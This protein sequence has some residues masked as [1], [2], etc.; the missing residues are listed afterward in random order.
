M[1]YEWMGLQTAVDMACALLHTLWQGLVLAIGLMVV[2]KCLP[3]ARSAL[4]YRLS[5]LALLTVVVCWVGTFSI[6]QYESPTSQ[7]QAAAIEPIHEPVTISAPAEQPT[8]R[9]ERQVTANVPATKAARNDLAVTATQN[10]PTVPAGELPAVSVEQPDSP[11]AASHAGVLGWVAAAWI[12]GVAVMLGRMF[13]LLC[14]TA[15]LRASAIDIDEP[16][17]VELFEQLC[18]EMGIKRV[19]RFAATNLLTQPGVIGVFRPVLLVPVSILSEI[20]V[21]DLRAILAHEL[22]HIRRYD[23]LV[24]FCQMLIEAVLFFNPGVWWIS[25]RIRIEREACCDAAGVKAAG[26][27]VKYAQILFEQ[28]RRGTAAPANMAVAGFSDGDENASTERVSRIIHPQKSPRMK[29]GAVKLILWLLIAAAVLAVL[30]KATSATVAVT[31]KILTPA[32]R[33]EKIAEIAE[34]HSSE[35]KDYKDTDRVTLSGTVTTHDGKSLPRDAGIFIKAFDRGSNTVHFN[36]QKDGSF[37]HS[38]R[39]RENVFVG[40]EV[41][42]Y[43][44]GVSPIYHP[45][46]NEII[47]NIEIVLTDGFDGKVQV[48]NEQGLPIANAV[49]N[50]HYFVQ[51][52]DGSSGYGHCPKV[53]SD[54]NGIAIFEHCHE[55]PVKMDVAVA[56]Y[57][58]IEDKE[59]TLRPDKTISVTLTKGL[60]ASG[61]VAAKETGKPIANAKFILAHKE[62]PGHSWHYGI[63]GSDYEAI[64]DAAGQF[65]LDTLA[66][67]FKYNYVIEANGYNR[68]VLTKVRPGDK[69]LRVEMLGELSIKGKVIGDLSKLSESYCSSLKKMVPALHYYMDFHGEGYDGLYKNGNVPVE[70]KDSVGTFEL[71]NILGDKVTLSVAGEEKMTVKIT[72]Q[73]VDDLVIDLDATKNFHDRATRPVVFTFQS[74]EG[75]PPVEGTVKVWYMTQEVEQSDRRQWSGLDMVVTNGI[76]KVDFPVNSY[77]R[78]A[79][80]KGL[81]G[82]W[83]EPKPWRTEKENFVTAGATPYEQTVVTEPGG[84][85]YGQIVDE[86]G[87]LIKY[88]ETKLVLVERPVKYKDSDNNQF[89][90]IK[91]KITDFGVHQNT[92]ET[93][94]FHTHIL[95]LGGSYAIVAFNKNTWL[96]SEPIELTEENPIQEI[97]LCLKDTKQIGGRILLPDKSPAKDVEVVLGV[98]ARYSKEDAHSRSGSA[99]TTDN[100]GTFLFEKINPQKPL[101]Y[102]LRIKPGPGYQPMNIHVKPGSEKTYRLEKGF[103]LT[104]TVIDQETGWPIPDAWVYAEALD[105]KD[106]LNRHRTC[107]GQTDKDGKFIFTT[108][109]DD[110]YRLYMG[111]AEI[112]KPGHKGRAIVGGEDQQ[113]DLT[114]RLHSWSQLKPREPEG[115]GND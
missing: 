112:V 50:K 101:E 76:G 58:K 43:A 4:R 73:S 78:L 109:N 40:V 93:G 33:I 89:H 105:N 57:Q 49:L 96:V 32:E 38:V 24:N 103:T 83:I 41:D 62:W 85:I 68:A 20:S 25:R 63:H 12:V 22:A 23:F 7:D 18:D 99:I 45:E 34:T 92:S 29:I 80:T 90:F 98:S 84:S 2:L 35:Y 69:G 66:E 74:P 37:K 110:R 77:L 9:P 54:E 26:R 31:A 87:Q 113:I 42:G 16:R 104:G 48:I 39:C 82:F 59:C 21:E 65:V 46:P 67:N 52:R 44:M 28:I 95:P 91:N 1:M 115:E 5:V 10:T 51:Y 6:L 70:I 53:T 111:G 8:T 61:L 79:E 3:A 17:W 71:K 14:G 81:K 15:K 64:S 114:V 36:I 56:G 30:W 97:T 102:T 75:Y 72:D 88:A 11:A 19:V 94:K 108:L 27:P 60:V 13:V 100:T 55:T 86:Q 106:Q 107:D 47:D